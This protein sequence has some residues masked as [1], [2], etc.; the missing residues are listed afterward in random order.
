MGFWSSVGSF[1]SGIVG[2]VG[3]IVTGAL[4]AVGRAV[5]AVCSALGLTKHTE[6]PEELGDKAL[7]AGEA[8]I[9]PEDYA[10]YCDYVKAIDEF[11]IDTEKS[12][13]FTPEEKLR[14]GTELASCAIQERFPGAPIV[15]LLDLSKDYPGLFT[16]KRF[17]ELARLQMS[18]PDTIKWIV[19]FLS[20]AEQ[21]DLNIDKGV[22]VLTAM[23]KA[24]NPNLSD[25]D[26]EVRVLN[27]R[28]R[29]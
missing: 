17:I 29:L 20:G 26:A 25:I 15:E 24:Q 12:N 5:M 13:L 16:D 10:T 28:S 2:G 14:K 8:G 3:H 11:E 1:V 4:S 19:G 21:N 6:K 23:E 9:K 18:D 7:Q 22:Q 27:M